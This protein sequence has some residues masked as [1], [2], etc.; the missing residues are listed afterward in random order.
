MGFWSSVGTFVHEAYSDFRVTEWL[1]QHGDFVVKGQK[2]AT[3]SY[4][5]STNNRVTAAVFAPVS[6]ILAEILLS[7]AFN[8]GSDTLARIYQ[9]D[10]SAT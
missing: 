6:G 1:C 9:I 7:D 4:K 5:S 8:S 10:E 2:I 3:V